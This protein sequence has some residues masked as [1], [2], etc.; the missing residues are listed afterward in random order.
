M[1]FGKDKIK[2]FSYARRKNSGWQMMM[3]QSIVSNSRRRRSPDLLPI[4]H[5]R[6]RRSPDLLPIRHYCRH[7]NSLQKNKA[8]QPLI[9]GHVI[10]RTTILPM[11]WFIYE[12]R[13]Y[14]NPMQVVELLIE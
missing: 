4:R 1:N 3:I 8:K 2:E 5:S 9:I 10:N 14:W 13:C 12:A 6:R 11:P 7:N